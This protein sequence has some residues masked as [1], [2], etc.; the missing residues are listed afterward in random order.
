MNK[1]AFLLIALLAAMALVSTGCSCGDDDDDDS[2]G[3]PDDDDTGPDD[4]VDDDDDDTGPDDD[5]D[6]T[7]DDDL[8]TEFD[9]LNCELPDP[10]GIAPSTVGGG[11]VSDTITVYVY[12][13]SPD[14]GTCPAI[15][16]ATVTTDADT[17]TTDVNGKATLDL[18]DAATT[19]T[20]FAD[21][22]WAWSYKADSNVMYFR[23]RPDN[24]DYS[25]DDVEGDFTT[26]GSPIG[27][28]NPGL[29]G[30]FTDPLYLGV[31]LPGI[32]RSG[33]L[34]QDFEN[35]LPEGEF[36]ITIDDG[37][38]PA[39]TALPEMIYLPTLNLTIPSVISVTGG[40]T[41]Y[42]V[43]ARDTTSPIEGFIIG[44]S[45]VEAIPD[46]A[47]LLDLID[48]IDLGGDI[49]ACIEPIV[50]PLVNDALAFQY[51]G[52]VPDWD[53]SGDSDIEV[54]ENVA[55]GT[56]TFNLDNED[57]DYDYLGILAAE[58]PNRSIVPLSVGIVD[59]GSVD[60]DSTELPDSDYMAMMAATD[61]I[62]SDFTSAN[63]SFALKYAEKLADWGGAVDFD[64]DTDFL[65]NF[66]TG[67]TGFN[68][69]TGEVSWALESDDD[70]ATADIYFVA[71]M[72]D[73]ADCPPVLAAV[74]GTDTSYQPPVGD[75]G[76]TPS[77]DDIVLVMG[78]DLPDGYRYRRLQSAR[79]VRLQQRV[80]QPLDEP[81]HHRPDPDRLRSVR[82]RTPPPG[83]LGRRAVFSLSLRPLPIIRGSERIDGT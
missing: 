37:G 58:I 53:G 7:G 3:T 71:Y 12:A 39:D 25:Y 40:N 28:T 69:V 72:A 20:A 73:C 10:E 55:K 78:V 22:Y 60:M 83:G 32:S 66:D 21:G 30:L 52:A 61:L 27:L 68:D 9:S 47:G 63:F 31:V 33:V 62:A 36:N 19:V 82:R 45:A 59:S 50:V 15:E 42:M 41:S 65:P 46:I 51:V 4:D 24:Y 57:T 2:G 49:L 80:L 67:S 34:S 54:T 14:G 13:D 18:T 38:G 77:A 64:G 29:L 76:I 74:P 16:G 56:T 26:G 75:L 48:C 23:L 35:F 81:R 44:L 8:D 43:A 1:L 5:D 6:D 79:P 70:K 11:A 17:Q